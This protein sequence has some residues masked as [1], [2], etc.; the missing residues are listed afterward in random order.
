MVLDNGFWQ[1]EDPIASLSVIDKALQVPHNFRELARL[2]LYASS[3]ES[4]CRQSKTAFR[5]ILINLLGCTRG[6]VTAARTLALLAYR[7]D[8]DEIKVC[9]N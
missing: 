4:E 7:V 6:D 1:V 9:P 2:F 3:V 5:H 8:R